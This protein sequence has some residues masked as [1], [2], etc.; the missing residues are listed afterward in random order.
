MPGPLR[1][2]H[3]SC[4]WVGGLKTGRGNGFGNVGHGVP[5]SGKPNILTSPEHPDIPIFAERLG[6]VGPQNYLR[7][8]RTLRLVADRSCF[9]AIV[10]PRALTKTPAVAGSVRRKIGSMKPPAL[11]SNMP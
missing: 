6:Y 4:L 8:R 9:S 1:I 3:L 2:R 11:E 10:R 7:A 5:K